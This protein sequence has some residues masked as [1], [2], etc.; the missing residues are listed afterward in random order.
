MCSRGSQSGQ[1]RSHSNTKTKRKFHVNLQS[2]AVD[3]VRMRICTRCIRTNTKH[4]KAA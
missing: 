3:G 1:R 4:A 2:K